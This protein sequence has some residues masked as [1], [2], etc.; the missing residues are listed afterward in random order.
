MKKAT[1]CRL[2]LCLFQ[3]DGERPVIGEGYVHVGAEG[4]VGHKGYGFTAFGYEIFI[5]FTC[6]FRL[7]RESEAG[8]VAVTRCV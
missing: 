3:N 2:S 7:C 6:Q 4:A 1:T 5:Q 8:S